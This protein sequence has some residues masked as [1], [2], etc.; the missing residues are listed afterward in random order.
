MTQNPESYNIFI[1]YRVEM[2]TG[3]ISYLSNIILG[4]IRGQKLELKNHRVMILM[5][6]EQ[7]YRVSIATSMMA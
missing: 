3:N 7:G 6:Q 2:A 1:Y 5:Q 4:H